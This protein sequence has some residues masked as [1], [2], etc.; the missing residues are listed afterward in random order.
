MSTS[1]ESST[2]MHRLLHASGSHPILPPDDPKDAGIDQLNFHSVQLDYLVLLQMGNADPNNKS[3]ERSTS[4]SAGGN[5]RSVIIG[6][7]QPITARRRHSYSGSHRSDDSVGLFGHDSTVG[8]S[9][10]GTQSGMLTQKLTLAE[11][12]THRLFSK[13]SNSSSFTFPLPAQIQRLKWVANER[14]K[15]GESSAT[16]IVKNKGWMLEKST[17]ENHDE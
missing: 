15:Q 1:G 16:K 3:K 11:E 4:Q 9:Q 2:T 10:R 7:R 6:A 8:Q 17:V 13:A 12:R 14:A 5:H